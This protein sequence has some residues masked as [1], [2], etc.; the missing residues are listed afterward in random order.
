MTSRWLGV[1][2]P[3]D[4]TLEADREEARALLDADLPV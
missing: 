2:L 1:R 4:L 3:T